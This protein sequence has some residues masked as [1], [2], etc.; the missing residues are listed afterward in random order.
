VPRAE[1]AACRWPLSS[2]SEAQVL[3]L[4]LFITSNTMNIASNQP[5]RHWMGQS[6]IWRSPGRALLSLC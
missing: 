1:R 4:E 6:S 3:R 5:W 2:D